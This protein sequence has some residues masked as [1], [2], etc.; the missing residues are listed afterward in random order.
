MALLF[1]LLSS[2]ANARQLPL[3]SFV[4]PVRRSAKAGPNPSPCVFVS[5][6]FYCFNANLCVQ[7]QQWHRNPAAVP[8]A[9]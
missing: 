2:P 3:R 9:S 7:G 6:S 1:C 8:M 4:R 5:F